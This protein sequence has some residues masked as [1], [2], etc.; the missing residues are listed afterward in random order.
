MFRQREREIEQGEGGD[1]EGWGEGLGIRQLCNFHVA[2]ARW[3]DG[4]IDGW[5]DAVGLFQYLARTPTTCT[6]EY[7]H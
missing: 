5:V 1:E 2:A 7:L 4:W 3:M 6:A